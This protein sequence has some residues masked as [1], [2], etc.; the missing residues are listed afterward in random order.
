MEKWARSLV[1]GERTDT[2]SLL[3]DL[4][5]YGEVLTREIA[6]G[7]EEYG[8]EKERRFGKITNPT[9]HIGM[10]Q[11]EKLVNAIIDVHGRPDQIVV[12]L[13]R[14]LKLNDKQKEEHKRRIK[15]DTDAAVARG[16]KLRSM[17]VPDTGA[18]RMLL[19]MWEELNPA[20]PLDRR[21]PYCGGMIGAEKLFDGSADIDHII[22]YS[23]SLDDSI[24]NKVVAH[25]NCRPMR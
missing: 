14:E 15:K 23:R 8:D 12:E 21:C 7:K 16:E 11:L 6:P 24:G 20:N 18:N 9:V 1:A 3:R 10:R 25:G 22:P 19:R 5:Y 17:G 2:L 4:P 13:A